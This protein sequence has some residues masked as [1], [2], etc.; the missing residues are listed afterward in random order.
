MEQLKKT[1]T[2]TM[3][4]HLP[5]PDAIDTERY[6]ALRAAMPAM[7]PVLLAHSL[8]TLFRRCQRKLATFIS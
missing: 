8:L 3:P 7:P 1:P 2:Q 5:N 4:A 6:L